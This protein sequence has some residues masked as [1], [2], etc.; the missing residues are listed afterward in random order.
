[1]KKSLILFSLLVSSLIA[2]EN[3]FQPTQTYKEEIDKMIELENGHPLKNGDIKS[4]SSENKREN[5]SNST[6][7]KQ[8]LPLAKTAVAKTEQE[9]ESKN[10]K[11]NVRVAIELP[12]TEKELKAM[13]S[14]PKPKAEEVVKKDIE[15]KETQNK[16]VA[17]IDYGN[18]TNTVLPFLILELSDKELQLKTKYK[19]FRKF[20]LETQKKIV[21]DFRGD[22]EFYTRTKTLDSKLFDSLMLGN[23]A[24]DS[25]FRVVVVVK[26]NP[27]K[28][29][30]T[31][32]EEGLRIVKP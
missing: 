24:P 19:V 2:R 25:F 12:K 6:T 5:N 16:E 14:A 11:S 30:V 13:L 32:N 22:V 7:A 9:I 10:K 17:T 29:E 1:M 31:Y 3:P 20:N 26:D 23:H 21:L 15:K 4:V 18:G 8:N 27:D 28:Y